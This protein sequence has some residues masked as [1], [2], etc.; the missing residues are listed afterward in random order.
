MSMV[1]AS[2][3]TLIQNR[4]V[5]G[6]DASRDI[7]SPPAST[8]TNLVW[9]RARAID[10]TAGINSAANSEKRSQALRGQWGYR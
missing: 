7:R 2:I 4:N 10:D 9:S 1:H 8:S 3:Q 5:R 6:H